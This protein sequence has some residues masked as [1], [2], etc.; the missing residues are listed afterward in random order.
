[1][2]IKKTPITKVA[3]AR[4]AIPA[5]SLGKKTQQK[6]QKTAVGIIGLGGVGGFTA[7]LCAQAGFNI[8]AADGD[9]VEEKNLCRQVLYAAADA[10]KSKAIVATARLSA[11]A[12]ASKIIAIAGRVD[13]KNI[14]SYFSGCDIILDCTDNYETRKAIEDYCFAAKKPWIYASATNQEAMVALI[15]NG[16]KILPRV[17]PK[18]K[19]P[20]TL[21]TTCAVA[22]ALQV[23]LLYDWVQNRKLSGKIYYFDLSTMQLASQKI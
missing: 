14:A 8:I 18:R 17:E 10:G 23:R 21:N 6:I 4:Y 15:T 20:T 3:L 1:M 5:N 9:A 13:K 11:I 2:A 16:K 19:P 7:T 22:A 12:P